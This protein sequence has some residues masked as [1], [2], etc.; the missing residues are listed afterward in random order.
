MSVAARIAM[1]SPK[2]ASATLGDQSALE[3]P[4]SSSRK[5]NGAG[6]AL[7]KARRAKSTPRANTE[8]DSKE[9]AVVKPDDRGPRLREQVR[10]TIE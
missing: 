7:L 1:F 2:A 6:A 5:S 9:L 3:N 10:C 8:S 4:Q